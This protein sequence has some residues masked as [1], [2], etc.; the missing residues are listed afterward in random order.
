MQGPTVITGHRDDWANT[1]H[2]LSQRPPGWKAMR[3]D[4]TPTHRSYL[5]YPEEQTAVVM[6]SRTPDHLAAA[7][8]AQ[9]LQRAP[10]T[11]I[12]DREVWIWAEAAAQAA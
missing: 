10:L 2:R 1:A 6:L 8:A 7:F 3:I 11:G 4:T 12:D 9:G 5:V